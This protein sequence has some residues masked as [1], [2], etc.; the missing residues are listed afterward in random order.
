MRTAIG[1]VVLIILSLGSFQA[2]ALILLNKTNSDSGITSDPGTGAPWKNVA[3]VLNGSSNPS[4][5][6]VYLG[7]QYLLTA[8]HVTVG[9]IV[10]DGHSFSV[11]SGFNNGD[12]SSGVQQIGTAD[13]KV[14][15][16]A[17]DPQLVVSGLVNIDLNTSSSQDI[18]RGVTLIGYGQGRGSFESGQGWNWGGGGTEEKRWGTNTTLNGSITVLGTT[19]LVTTFDNNSIDTE[20]ALTMNDSGSG[21]FFEQGSTWYLGGIGITVDVNGSSFYDRDLSTSGDQPDW[22]YFA[23][24]SAYESEI[25]SAIATIPEPPSYALIGIALFVFLFLRRTGNRHIRK[26]DI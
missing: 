11:D 4:G 26:S 14:L 15:R 23:R 24:I 17:S 20:A 22:N 8:N 3:Q 2:Q 7:N 13:L 10:I 18:N 5:S 12:F 25:S 6:G 21:L 9:S 16:L 1:L 19:S